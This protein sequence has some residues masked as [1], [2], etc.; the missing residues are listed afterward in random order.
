MSSFPS[1]VNL[2]VVSTCFKSPTEEKC[3][4]S[5]ETQTLKVPHVFIDAALQEVPKTHS[6]NLYDAVKVLDPDD[7]VIQLDGD[8]W[9]AHPR[10]L[11]TVARLYEDPNVWLTY[12][13]FQLADGSYSRL[14]GPYTPYEDVR[15]A[16]WRCS[17]LKTFRAGLFQCINPQD[18][19]LPDGSFTGRAVDHATMFPMVEMA[20]WDRTRWVKEALY[21][22]NWENSTENQSAELNAASLEAAEFFRGKPRYS[23]ISSYKR[24]IAST[25]AYRLDVVRDTLAK[26]SL[27][28]RFVGYEL[29][30]SYE[31]PEKLHF[32]WVGSPLPEKYRANV[33]GFA[34]DNPSY[35][36]TLWVDCETFP[37]EGVSVE[38][39]G[40]LRMSHR[41]L[42]DAETNWGAKADIA[43]Y[44]IVYQHGGVY[45]D[46]D[47]Q[48]LKPFD[49]R[50]RHAF[51][52]ATL[53]TW[54][55]LEN[56]MFGFS[57]GSTFLRFVLDNLVHARCH[58]NVPART[59]PTFFTTC[60]LSA[61]DD[62]IRIYDQDSLN[63]GHAGYAHHTADANWVECSRP[64][65]AGEEVFFANYEP[66]G[67]GS[68]VGSEVGYTKP[69]R[70]YLNRFL[71]EHEIRSV[72]DYACGDQQWA[73]FVDWGDLDYLGLDIV[74]GLI[75]RLR[76]EFPN[77]R[78]QL[79]SGEIPEADLIL[80]KDL[81]I[82]LPLE[83]IQE[84]LAKFTAKGKHF[85]S[86]ESISHG[87]INSQIARGQFRP[88]DLGAPPFNLRG[89]R[90]L[91]FGQG[92]WAGHKVAFHWSKIPSNRVQQVTAAQAISQTKDTKMKIHVLGLP[93]TQTTEEFSTCAFTQ[94]TVTLCKMLTRRGHHVTHYGVE[95]SNPECTENVSVMPREEWAKMFG[96]PG[97]EFYKVDVSGPFAP[98]HARYAANLRAAILER[99]G[100]P[101]TEIICHPWNGTQPA[102]TEGIPQYRVESGIGY[103]GAWAPW[104]IYESYAWL[105]M[106]LGHA[107]EFAGAK[108]YWSVIPNAFDLSKFSE[109]KVQ[110]GG[111]F[112][113]LGR[114]NMDKG[115]GIAC[116]TAKA[117]GARITIVGQGDPTPFL[118]P[119]V[120]YRP[121]VGIEERREL[122]ANARALFAPTI[123]VEPFGSTHVEAMLSGTPVITSDW[124]VFSE[125]N[126]H[127]LTGYRCRTMEQFAWAARN[128]GRIDGRVCAEWART[129]FSMER[130]VLQ[131][132][133]FFDQCLRVRD[134]AGPVKGPTGF[135][136]TN[137]DRSELD[138]LKRRYPPDA[139]RVEIDLTLPVKAPLLEMPVTVSPKPDDLSPRISFVMR[140]HNEEETL[141]ESVT[142]LFA[143]SVPIE[144]VV[145]LHRCTDDS[146]AIANACK[147]AMPARHKMQ[148]V[149]REQPISRAGLETFVT[150]VE[151]PHSLM[152]YYKYAFGLASSEWKFK[153]D[154]DFVATPGFVRWIE[155][156]DWSAKHACVLNFPH[157]LA[158]STD[159]KN[160]EPYAHNCLK[161]FVKLD[162]WEVPLFPV[163]FAMEDV[164]DEAAFIHKS[165]LAEV[166]PYWREKPWFDGEGSAEAAR[167]RAAY[168]HAVTLV[169]PEPVGCARSC[170]PEADDYLRRCRELLEGAGDAR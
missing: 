29:E 17:H 168:N 50:L 130:V 34:R 106:H 93:H 10:V 85:I 3:R 37:P 92:H 123:Y 90:E 146:K 162:F 82:H 74:P 25:D 99:T 56:G 164:P 44:E 126:L 88:V 145:V 103:R 66:G 41:D 117:V 55:N 14:N 144:I 139:S 62:R 2:I 47:S 49:G 133:E 60:F 11:E 150:P 71:K 132:E 143:I 8:D 30:L 13:S 109:P 1:V 119:H 80:C 64:V 158:D 169:G 7:I 15:T 122:L 76:A 31:V 39:V 108:W 69:L 54:H 98:Y 83:D 28:I 163:D 128:I 58:D 79:V 75:D 120:T 33:E 136:G 121:P 94:K 4:T 65:R 138:W 57:R 81:F 72:V 84:L 32:I 151:S 155:G 125:T 112:L 129:N 91:E 89:Q 159:I 101:F 157:R 118:A 48:S 165:S 35:R 18:L 67:S 161:S 68:G 134:M 147:R 77:R 154:G 170:N 23:R 142:S 12:G 26:G 97:K 124:G 95:G 20:G 96:H 40:D 110:R 6:E 104:R 107:S 38:Q 27:S 148:I 52:G 63:M 113:Y 59:G 19:R 153:W 114:L 42:Y 131:Y 137:P 160:R 21:V 51:V 43:R 111:E 102:A 78:F 167:L 116:D 86:V 166:K 9:L 46:I 127:G 135:Y 115:V 5:V 24:E 100:A 70:E 141:L 140:V 87:V 45:C 53:N 105:H 73:K 149:E 156:Q 61:N 22:Y 152:S 16:R 36:V